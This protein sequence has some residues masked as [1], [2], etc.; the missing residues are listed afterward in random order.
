MVNYLVV[1]DQ[2]HTLGEITDKLSICC[3]RKLAANALVAT[4]S[5]KSRTPP[6][7]HGCD[8]KAPLLLVKLD[9]IIVPILID[10]RQWSTKELRSIYTERD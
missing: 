2:H 10:Q 5:H 3:L 6:M 4:D 1:R 9:P 8:K 7:G